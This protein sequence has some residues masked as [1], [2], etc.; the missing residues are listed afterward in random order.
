MSCTICEVCETETSIFS[1][2]KIVPLT[3]SIGVESEEEIESPVD[4][5]ES[6]AHQAATA[7]AEASRFWEQQSNR[8]PW[9]KTIKQHRAGILTHPVSFYM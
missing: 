7:A 3:I 5:L 2:S 9:V 4:H 6:M 8:H 1:K